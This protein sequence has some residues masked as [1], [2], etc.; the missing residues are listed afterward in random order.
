M[1]VRESR[2]VGA[3][4]RGVLLRG[5]GQQQVVQVLAARGR[6]DDRLLRLAVVLPGHGEDA[7]GKDSGGRV[8]LLLVAEDERAPF[9]RT[10]VTRFSTI[11]IASVTTIV[12]TGVYGALGHLPSWAALIATNYGRIIIAKA[13]LL[14]PLVMLG[15]GV[16]FHYFTDTVGGLL[17]GSA[18]VCVAA[19][20]VD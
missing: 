17:L 15:V 19:Q 14:V 8:R 6:L 11:A 9:A 4:E 12:V 13:V 16:T 18:V 3:H 5:E 1:D 20:S 10:I 2:E 7:A